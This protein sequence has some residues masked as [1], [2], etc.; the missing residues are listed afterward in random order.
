MAVFQDHRHVGPEEL[1]HAVVVPW[2]GLGFHEDAVIL[3][4]DAFPAGVLRDLEARAAVVVPGV[5]VGDAELR[6]LEMTRVDVD[7]FLLGVIPPGMPVA[8]GGEDGVPFPPH[9]VEADGEEGDGRV[10]V[11]ALRHPLHQVLDVFQE[12]GVGIVGLQHAG[13]VIDPVSLDEVAGFVVFRPLVEDPLRGTLPGPLFGGGDAEGHLPPALQP[14]L[15]GGVDDLPVEIVFFRLQ[16]RPGQAEED[17]AH[18]GE[19]FDDVFGS[20]L[21]S[22]PV[23]HVGVIIEHPSHSGIDE[24]LAVVRRGERF[25]VGGLRPCGRSCQHGQEDEGKYPFHRVFFSR[26]SVI[27]CKIRKNRE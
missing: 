21:R 4:G 23:Q 16:E 27:P 8:R 24:G 9:A 12:D 11:I 26:K 14:A 6:L 13:G 7:V 19:I 15:G 17:D 22:V 5:V 18:S 2:I 20:E 10:A 3:D 25:H 1:R